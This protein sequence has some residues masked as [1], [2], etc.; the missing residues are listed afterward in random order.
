MGSP[1]SFGGIASGL[2]T[3]NI[4]ASLVGLRRQ[5]IFRLQTQKDSLNQGLSILGDLKTAVTAFGAAAEKLSSRNG[6][7]AKGGTSSNEDAF[8]AT[9]TSFAALGSYAIDIQ[10]LATAQRDVSQG[11]AEATTGVG[12]GTFSVTANGETTDI[13]VN[14]G[15][16]LADLKDAING[17]GA[18]VTATIINDGVDPA[19]RLVVSSNETGSSGAF[20]LDASGLSGGLQPAFDVNDQVA[21]GDANFTIDGIAIVSSSNSPSTAIEGITISLESVGAGTLTVGADNEELKENLQSFVDAYNDVMT[22][23][24]GQS[25]RGAPL[26]G[27]SLVRAIQDRVTGVLNRSVANPGSY[28]VVAEAGLSLDQEGILALD[29]A[30]LE[31]ALGTDFE[32]V[33]SLFIEENGSVGVAA[34]LTNVVDDITDFTQGLFKTRE[35]AI[36]AQI[37]NI[38]GRIEREERSVAGYEE[39]LNRKFTALEVLVSRL[40]SQSGFLF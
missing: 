13:T 40:Q 22:I 32:S 11:F 38:D 30:K 28:R 17:A 3:Q 27:S 33:T 14:P 9:A 12:S 8:T 6:F 34:Q 4:V 16:T 7:V 5:P 37:K 39:L 25:E 18:G 10:N 23:V 2:D 29:G 20:S 19:F 24:N 35:N 36:D 21:A 31:E 26:N 1:I 15:S